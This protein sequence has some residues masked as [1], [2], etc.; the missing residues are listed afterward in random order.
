VWYTTTTIIKFSGDVV[1]NPS[2]Q[3][4]VV[5]TGR[6]LKGERSHKLHAT[7]AGSMQQCMVL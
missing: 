5:G 2:S 7:N 4:F 3:M 6:S 1:N